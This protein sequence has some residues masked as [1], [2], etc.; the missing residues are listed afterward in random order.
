MSGK[1]CQLSLSSSFSSR[2]RTI[3]RLPF[4]GRMTEIGNLCTVRG[5]ILI[6]SSVRASCTI[7]PPFFSTNTQQKQTLFFFF[8]T[9]PAPQYRCQIY[10]RIP[11]AQQL[12]HYALG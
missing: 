4:C 9:P 8:S 10:I 3:C 1:S 11:N 12:S 2:Q 7:L 5:K 6:P